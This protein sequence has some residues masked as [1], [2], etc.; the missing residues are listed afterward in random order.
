M[1]ASVERLLLFTLSCLQI[2]FDLKF[3]QNRCDS[4]SICAEL[5]QDLWRKICKSGDV[6][7]EHNLFF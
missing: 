1:E 7:F 3:K 5:P 2:A 6:N 4:Y